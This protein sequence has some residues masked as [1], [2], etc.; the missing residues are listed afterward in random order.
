[1]R[2]NA[3]VEIS[4]KVLKTK[5]VK[6]VKKYGGYC[7]QTRE[8]TSLKSVL[9]DETSQKY[10]SKLARQKANLNRYKSCLKCGVKYKFMHSMCEGE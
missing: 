7:E 6:F 9:L 4:K 2:K 5:Q 1:M 8:G 10:Y 3:I